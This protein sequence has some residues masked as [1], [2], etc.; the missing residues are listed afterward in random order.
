[1]DTSV[2]IVTIVILAVVLVSDLGTRKITRLR[3]VRPFIAAVV[4]IPFFAKAVV[5][6]GNGLLLEIAGAAAGL[7]VGVLAAAF[8]RVR[9]DS[10]TGVACSRAGAGYALVWVAVSAGRVLF[11]YGSHHW[12]AA[13]LV[14]WGAAH[15]VSIAALTDALIFF[16][17]AMLLARTGSLAARAHRAHRAHR[18][19]TSPAAGTV[20]SAYVA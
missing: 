11:D 12:F 3:L 15:Q 16:S 8:L 7:A 4:V 9:R 14:A 6:S 2:L 5:S 19:R 18:A 10:V 1:V 17:V 13:Q 20:G